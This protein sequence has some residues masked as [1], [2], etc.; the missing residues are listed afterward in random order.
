M[1]KL[2]NTKP[3]KTKIVTYTYFF[4]QALSTCYCDHDVDRR[5]KEKNKTTCIR[6]YH[7]F[8][9]QLC[10]HM[11]CQTIFISYQ[12]QEMYISA[13]VETNYSMLFVTCTVDL[14]IKVPG[15]TIFIHV[16]IFGYIIVMFR[17]PP[18]WQ[19]SGKLILAA[20]VL[21]SEC[22]KQTCE[23]LKTAKATAYI[24]KLVKQ[25]AW[26]WFQE[27]L[28]DLVYFMFWSNLYTCTSWFKIKKKLW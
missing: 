13:T 5:L 6:F 15:H 27:L 25:P 12:K 28:V 23:K 19:S 24:I 11:R 14:I 2:H 21:N 4:N 20:A 16:A 22:E 17:L 1:H 26:P 10:A 7:A 8:K 3:I 9:Q 18:I